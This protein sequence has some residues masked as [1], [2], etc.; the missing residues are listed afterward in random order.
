[1]PDYGRDESLALKVKNRDTIAPAK[2]T[3]LQALC[4]TDG[5]AD[6]KAYLADMALAC[7]G[8]FAGLYNTLSA[9]IELFEPILAIIALVDAGSIAES[10]QVGHGSMLDVLC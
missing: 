7:L 4:A 1:M 2:P 6:V 9:F 3:L 8:E 10:L 5:S